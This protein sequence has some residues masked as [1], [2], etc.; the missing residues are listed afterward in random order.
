MVQGLLIETFRV[1]MYKG[2]EYRGSGSI[3]LKIQG[4]WLG[5][6]VQGLYAR[7][8]GSGYKGSGSLGKKVQGLYV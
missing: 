5:I 4:L 1:S 8:K 2:S 3:G 6:E 7:Y